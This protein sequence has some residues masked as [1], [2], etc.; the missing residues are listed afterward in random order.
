MHET[1]PL[2]SVVFVTYNRLE[3]LRPTLSSFLA[4]TAWPRDRLELI[5]A[6]DGSSLDVRKELQSMPFDKFVFGEHAGL[7]KNTNR[8]I[9]AASGDYIL[10]LQDDWV[11][12]GP[13]DY[14][15]RG[16]NVFKSVPEAGIVL[17]YK[18]PKPPAIKSRQ[19]AGSDQIHVYDN[20]LTKSILYVGQ[21]SAY[22]DWPHLKRRELHLDLG[23]Y[24]ENVKMAYCELDFAQRIGSQTKHYI[25]DIVGL[26]AFRNI[27]SELSHQPINFKVRLAR[28]IESVSLGKYMYHEYMAWKRRRLDKKVIVYKK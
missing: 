27:G 18:H 12:Q 19:T 11:C 6:D 17:L 1:V 8:G 21:N 14:L 7:G 24:K 15:Q 23:L 10:H 5:V 9:R 4:R 20:D 22:S 13:A 3:T 16:V 28:T 2:I 25:A 26:D